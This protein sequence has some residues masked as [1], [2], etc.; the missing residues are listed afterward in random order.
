MHAIRHSHQFTVLCHWSEAINCQLS[1][2]KSGI[3]LILAVHQ[4]L[5]FADPKTKRKKN[6]QA[7]SDYV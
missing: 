4:T 2:P 5:T 6:S 3:K 1:T 7:M